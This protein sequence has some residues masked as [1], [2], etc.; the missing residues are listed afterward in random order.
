MRRN[1][2]EKRKQTRTAQ[3]RTENQK[4]RVGEK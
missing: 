4:S 2:G 1:S 3:N